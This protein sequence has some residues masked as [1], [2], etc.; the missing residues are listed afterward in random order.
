[1]LQAVQFAP[2]RIFLPHFPGPVRDCNP[3]SN[4][5]R[6]NTYK[7]VWKQPRNSLWIQHSC[8]TGGGVQAQGLTSLLLLLS[9]PQSCSHESARY[10]RRVAR[11]RPPALSPPGLLACAPRQ[12]RAYHAPST[13][14][15][16]ASV[17]QADPHNRGP[18]LPHKTQCPAGISPATRP[19]QAAVSPSTHHLQL[20]PPNSDPHSTVACARDSYSIDESKL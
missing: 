10:L 9:P 14:S 2:V 11:I 8:K 4:T 7:S 18:R 12:I 3:S 19:P 13:L 5:R 15:S 16:S 1:M 17:H 6:I 20:G